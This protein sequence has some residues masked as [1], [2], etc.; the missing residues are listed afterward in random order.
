MAQEGPAT[1]RVAFKD[2]GFFVP[3]DIAGKTVT[4]AGTLKKRELS[5]EE[6]DHYSKDLDDEGSVR[7]GSTYE[8]VATA[9][10]V[11]RG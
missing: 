3:T 10:R 9:V 4:L 7:A 1:I 5:A 2:Y 6:A 8:I 11:P